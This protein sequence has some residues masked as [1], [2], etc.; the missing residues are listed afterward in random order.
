MSKN[1]IAALREF[2]METHGLRIEASQRGRIAQV[3]KEQSRLL[4]NLIE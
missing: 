3:V 2:M 1:S 4:R